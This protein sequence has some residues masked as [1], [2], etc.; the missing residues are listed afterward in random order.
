MERGR[1]K[2]PAVI[3]A[4]TVGALLLP[5]CSGD[6]GESASTTT[7]PDVMMPNNDGDRFAFGDDISENNLVW[8]CDGPNQVINDERGYG[9]LMVVPSA[10]A[11]RNADNPPNRS[12]MT[13][14][15]D[16][17]ENNVVVGCLRGA[18]IYRQEDPENGNHSGNSYLA[19]V[20]STPGLCGQPE[21]AG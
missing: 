3:L 21:V 11:C 12:R 14:G 9:A 2:K 15:D 19:Q 20:I 1:F 17:I 8:G 5:S 4:F 6:D 16:I 10:F 13:F 18:R 7:N